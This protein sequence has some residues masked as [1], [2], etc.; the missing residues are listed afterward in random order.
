MILYHVSFD[1]ENTDC[2]FYPRVP[3]A[4]SVQED[5]ITPRICLSDSIEH[6]LQAVAE[7]YRRDLTPGCRLAVYSIDSD[8]IDPSFLIFPEEL[9]EKRLVPDA[10]ENQE[11]W[12]LEGL[13]MQRELVRVKDFSYEYTLAF[14]CM[15][16]ADVRTII[17]GILPELTLP[18]TDS[19]EWLY[20]AATDYMRE[21]GMYHEWDEI[22][23]ALAELPFAQKT[24]IY[25]LELVAVQREDLER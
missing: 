14:S 2:Y 22:W 21:Y 7:E 15:K 12:A 18:D 6:C 11:Y 3:F 17:M 25:D 10:M 9:F 1:T 13:Y 8:D 4:I 20:Q 24:E 19:A 16:S 5:Q 23:D